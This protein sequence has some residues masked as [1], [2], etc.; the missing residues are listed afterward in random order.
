MSLYYGAN[1]NMSTEH[2]RRSP[3]SKLMAFFGIG[4]LVHILPQQKNAFRGVRGV[5]G[6]PRGTFFRTFFAF[7]A[8]NGYETP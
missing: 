4:H 7:F 3:E 8:E 2:L 5:Q 6:G 1:G